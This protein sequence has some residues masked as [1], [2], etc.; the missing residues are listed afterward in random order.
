[1]F[2]VGLPI[3]ADKIIHSILHG[4]Y[5]GVGMAAGALVSGFVIDAYGVQPQFLVMSIVMAL[6]CLIHLFVFLGDQIEVR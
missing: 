1:M 2:I 3:G 5:W 6:L 4:S